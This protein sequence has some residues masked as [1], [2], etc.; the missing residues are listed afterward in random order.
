MLPRGLYLVA[1]AVLGLAAAAPF[2]AAPDLEYDYEP[3]PEG[4]DYEEEIEER[5]KRFANFFG[6]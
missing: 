2:D 4:Y 5:D 3:G 6:W 1:V